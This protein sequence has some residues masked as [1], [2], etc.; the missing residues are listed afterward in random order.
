MLLLVHPACHVVNY[1]VDYS[2]AIMASADLL[3]VYLLLLLDSSGYIRA[4]Q[5]QWRDVDAT[6]VE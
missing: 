5:L 1:S 2:R 6:G 3:N 4:T